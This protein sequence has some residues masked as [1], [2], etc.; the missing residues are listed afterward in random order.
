MMS[1]TKRY[2]SDV[3][4]VKYNKQSL[5]TPDVTCLSHGNA[6]DLYLNHEKSTMW[7]EGE[8]KQH[9]TSRQKN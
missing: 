5:G 4:I 9:E 6:T 2:C 8:R 3:P 7:I 1:Q